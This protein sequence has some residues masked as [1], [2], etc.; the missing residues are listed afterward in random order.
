[1]KADLYACIR[2]FDRGLAGLSV[3]LRK[4]IAHAAEQ[5]ISEAQLFEARLYP[6]MFPLYRQAQIVCDFARQAPSRVLELDVPRELDG[7]MGHDELQRQ[8]TLAREFIASL[9]ADQFEARDEREIMFPIGGNPTTR[10]AA[11]YL[12]GFATPNFYFHL[13]TAYAILR[14]RGV[15][16]GKVDYFGMGA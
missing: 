7:V 14:S 2:A 11:G 9:T 4:G 3:V 5:R 6:D 16:L 8:I 13:V 10:Q 12:L 1:M 15:S